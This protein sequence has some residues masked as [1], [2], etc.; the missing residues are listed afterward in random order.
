MFEVRITSTAIL[1]DKEQN[2]T[3]F[4]YVTIEL[5]ECYLRFY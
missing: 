2:V 1:D 5:G 4:K 3:L